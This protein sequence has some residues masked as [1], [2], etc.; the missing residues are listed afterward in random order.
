MN[1]KDLKSK[2]NDLLVVHEDDGSY[3]LFGKYKIVPDNLGNFELIDVLDGKTSIHRFFTLKNAVTYCVFDKN[4]MYKELKRIVELDSL[5]GGIDV[6]ILQHQ[7]LLDKSEDRDNKS[8]FLAK[9]MES[10]L[11]KR[12]M[13]KEI[14]SYISISKHWQSKKFEENQAR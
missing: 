2:I 13:T 1:K 8:I 11:K 12:A 5:L 7:R 9:L 14:N 10:K 6:L 3:F 4:N